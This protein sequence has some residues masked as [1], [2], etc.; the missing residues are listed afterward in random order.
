MP[1]K[2]ILCGWVKDRTPYPLSIQGSCVRTAVAVRRRNI[3][4]IGSPTSR[5]WPIREREQPVSTSRPRPR[6]RPGHGLRPSTSAN[7][8]DPHRSQS[9]PHLVRSN[10]DRR[11]HGSSGC[12]YAR[13]TTRGNPPDTGGN[14]FSASAMTAANKGEFCARNV[15][16]SSAFPCRI[17]SMKRLSAESASCLAACRT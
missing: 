11:L 4:A 13:R 17:A 5:H 7:M 14:A 12:W 3:G 8:P 16:T 15:S 6:T 9:W 1:W 10:A 2:P